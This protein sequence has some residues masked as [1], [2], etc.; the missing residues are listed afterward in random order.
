[1]RG[2]L[3]RSMPVGGLLLTPAKSVH[4][5]GMRLPIDVAHL[6]GDGRVLTAV[7]MMPNRLGRVVWRARHVLEA[8]AGSFVS[9]G[10]EVGADLRWTDD[11]FPEAA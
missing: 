2:L 9:W 3:K 5:L 7:T 11:P 1:M 6:S 10:V 4:T 8:P